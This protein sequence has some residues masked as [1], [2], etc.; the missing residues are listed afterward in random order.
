MRRLFASLLVVAFLSGCAASPYVEARFA[1]QVD[2]WS[3]WVLQPERDWICSVTEQGD[4]NCE[5]EVRLHVQAGMEWSN[6]TSC[7]ADSMLVGPYSQAFVGCS[8]MFGGGDERGWFIQPELRHQID[9]LTSD[10]LGTDQKQWQGHN[11]F[12]HLRAGYRYGPFKVNI[13]SGKSLFQGAPFE[14]EEG[15]PDLYWTNIEVGARWGGYTGK[16]K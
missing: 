5:N 11:P 1:Y 13:A 10:F 4:R 15:A 12:V 8:K 6:R 9:D 2:P 3:D 16:W 7:F 14:K